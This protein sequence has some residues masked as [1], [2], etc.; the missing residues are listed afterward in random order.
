MHKS[1]DPP[2]PFST[3]RQIRV[4]DLDYNIRAVRS[5]AVVSYACFEERYES[6]QLGSSIP[7]TMTSNLEA[8]AEVRAAPQT[9]LLI[10]STYIRVRTYVCTYK[11]LLLTIRNE[12]YFFLSCFETVK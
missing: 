11:S 7:S 1:K 10:Y 3:T 12:S 9:G 5:L 8:A 4:T 2:P 6:L